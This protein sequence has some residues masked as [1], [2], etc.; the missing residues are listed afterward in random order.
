MELRRFSRDSTRLAGWKGVDSSASLTQGKLILDLTLPPLTYRPR[1]GEHSTY[2]E[3]M[4]T[5]QAVAQQAG[6]IEGACCARNSPQDFRAPLAPCG[7]DAFTE[8]DVSS[9]FSD[10]LVKVRCR[11][12]VFLS[13][14]GAVVAPSFGARTAGLASLLPSSPRH[15]VLD[16]RSKGSILQD[17]L[18]NSPLLCKD[19]SLA[20]APSFS[21]HLQPHVATSR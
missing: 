19:P 2:K 17:W 5:W 11:V 3:V 4:A 21:C 15:C 10:P 16:R 6:R 13:K 12:A 14:I 20:E 8:A 7:C 18:S 9:G 1:F